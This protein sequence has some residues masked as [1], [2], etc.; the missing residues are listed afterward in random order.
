VCSFISLGGIGIAVSRVFMP[1]H[2]WLQP[3]ATWRPREY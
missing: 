3:R 2:Q 1:E